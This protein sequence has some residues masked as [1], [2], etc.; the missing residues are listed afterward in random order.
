MQNWDDLRYF[1]SVAR[2]GSFSTAAE[3]LSVNGSTVGRRI[4]QLGI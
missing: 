3:S 4:D 2:S 1:L